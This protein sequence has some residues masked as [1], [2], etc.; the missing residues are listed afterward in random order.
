MYVSVRRYTIGAGSIDALAH[1]LEEEFAPAISQE[2][3]FLGYLAID[4]GD[5]M[6]ETL[7]V[8][9]DATSAHRSDEL[10]ADYVAEYLS[11]FEPTRTGV[12]GGD[13]LPA[14]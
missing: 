10:A 2:P 11:E 8:F 1:R 4:A 14:A 7:S 6:V 9:V 3:G 12:T 5:G 13:V